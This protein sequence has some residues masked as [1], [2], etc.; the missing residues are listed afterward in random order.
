MDGLKPGSALSQ[1]SQEQGALRSECAVSF[2]LFALQTLG[3]LRATAV[4]C[5]LQL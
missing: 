1:A 5:L 2:V 4:S 3:R